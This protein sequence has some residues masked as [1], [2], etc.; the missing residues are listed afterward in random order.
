MWTK[1]EMALISS[2]LRTIGIPQIILRQILFH[3]MEKEWWK[4]A[5]FVLRRQWLLFRACQILNFPR[6]LDAHPWWGVE[7]GRSQ[8]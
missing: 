5:A 3:F 4:Q 6:T 2:T 1:E 7:G 8:K